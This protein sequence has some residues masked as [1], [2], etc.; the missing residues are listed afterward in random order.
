M[1]CLSLAW[2]ADRSFRSPPA[3]CSG[4]TDCSVVP[5]SRRQRRFLTGL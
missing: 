3:A 1:I 4:R 2:M 5:I